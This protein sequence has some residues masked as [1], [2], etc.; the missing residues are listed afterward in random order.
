MSWIT[1]LTLLGALG[2]GIWFGRPRRFDQNLDELDRL[3][4]Q[5]RGKHQKVKR[6]ATFVNFIARK[7]QKGSDRRRGS[8]K[9]F[10]LG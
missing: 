2:L 9:P 6:H 3:I 10:R 4:S 5:P 7:A 8:R 1:A